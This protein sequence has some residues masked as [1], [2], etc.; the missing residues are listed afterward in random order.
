MRIVGDEL[1]NWA[2]EH[3]LVTKTVRELIFEGYDDK[4]LDVL[5]RLKLKKFE[6]PFDRFGWFVDRNG[7]S[8]YDGRFH[9]NTGTDDIGQLGMLQLWNFAGHTA[10]AG[11]CGLVQGTTG[12]LWPP[13]S[14]KQRPLEMFVG[15]V[16]RKIK[17]RYDSEGEKFSVKAQKYVMDESV[18]DNGWHY[19]EAACY[20]TANAAECPDLLPGALNVSACKFGAPAFLSLPHFYM[21]DESYRAKING[22]QP[23]AEKHSFYMLLER[24]LGIPLEVRGGMQ[25]NLLID[26]YYDMG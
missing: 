25:I 19:P 17:L 11:D 9:M 12:E 16:C 24:S 14:D 22:M 5:R 10:Y 20:C 13:V 2:G 1:M 4:I 3:L 15:D 23:N 26:Q 21:G 6:I 7:S 8:S 18:L